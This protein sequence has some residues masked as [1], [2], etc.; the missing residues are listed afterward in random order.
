MTNIVAILDEHYVA[1]DDCLLNW[2]EFSWTDVDVVLG[3]SEGREVKAEMERRGWSHLVDD[4]LWSKT[5]LTVL[6]KRA[7]KQELGID[8]DY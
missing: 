2:L 4:Q 8:D 3:E 6:L 1:D 5:G 7:I